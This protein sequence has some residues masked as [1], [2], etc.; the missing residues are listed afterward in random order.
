MIEMVRDPF[1]AA[2]IKYQLHFCHNSLLACAYMR[3]FI[4]LI[5]LVC[6]FILEPLKLKIVEE[7]HMY[8]A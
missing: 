2:S 6:Y 5:G 7:V 8:Q 3:P 4:I 1:T